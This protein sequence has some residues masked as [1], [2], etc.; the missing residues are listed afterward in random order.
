MVITENSWLGA[1]LDLDFGGSARMLGSELGEKRA[2]HGAI[3]HKARWSLPRAGA[4]R[5]P[6]CRWRSDPGA[7]R[8][9]KKVQIMRRSA[10]FGTSGLLGMAFLLG[11][12]I[13]RAEPSTATTETGATE[14]GAAELSGVGAV[15]VLPPDP[16]SDA[17]TQAEGLL[18]QAKELFRNGEYRAALPLIERAYALTNAPR[19]LFNLGTLHHKLS[20]CVPARDYFE[21]YLQRDPSGDGSAAALSALEELRARCPAQATAAPA[22]LALV[23]ATTEVAPV[24]APVGAP[25]AAEPLE[26]SWAPSSRA[27]VLL[28]IGAAAGIGALAS[29]VA[30]GHAQSEIDALGPLVARQGDTWDAHEARR[31]ELASNARLYRGL[32]LG[33]G[34]ACAAFVG[35]GTTV[36][37]LEAR[38]RDSA[39]SLAAGVTYRARF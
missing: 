11:V 19:F 1:S 32:S 34:V 18:E 33:L 14:T 35:A 15:G 16:A 10:P 8:P 2:P 30:R 3:R 36:W 4:G 27:A 12:S 25:P 7:R 6:G 28:G 21:Q 39:R 37:I 20:E 9:S 24:L 17:R 23:P 38:E 13:A 29:L 26:R 5:W 22:S 31:H